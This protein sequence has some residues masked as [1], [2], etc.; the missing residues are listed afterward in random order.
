MKIDIGCAL[1]ILLF[2]F[3]G[4]L[5]IIDWVKHVIGHFQARKSWKKA[6]FSIKNGKLYVHDKGEDPRQKEPVLQD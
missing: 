4:S 1:I 3:L 6:G 2:A 5:Y